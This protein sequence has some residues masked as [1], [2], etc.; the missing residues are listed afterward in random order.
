MEIT[1][2]IKK[3]NS[4]Q[5][6]GAKNFRTRSMWLVTNDKYPQTLQ[7]EFLQDKVNL[8]DNFTEG[9]FVRTAIN[10]R[11]REWQN[12]QGEVKVFNTI[13]GWK[14]EDDVEQVS[15]TQQSPDRNNDLPF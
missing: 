5:T 7:V 12:P 8:L 1:G 4:T 9:S 3:I 13:E 2:R 15:A 14:L 11:G 6:R 10:L